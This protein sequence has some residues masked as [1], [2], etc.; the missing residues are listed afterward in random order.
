MHQIYKRTLIPEVLLLCNFIEITFRHGRSPV[1]MLH[2]FRTPFPKN[3]SS[4]LRLK[5]NFQKLFTISFLFFKKLFI[6]VP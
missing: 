3:T 4:G 6:T 5:L 1:N 2:I